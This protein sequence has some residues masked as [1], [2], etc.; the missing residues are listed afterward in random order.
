[1]T[2]E[3]YLRIVL[4][5]LAESNLPKIRSHA[6]LSEIKNLLVPLRSEF[7]PT[8]INTDI[9]SILNSIAFFL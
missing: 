8:Y 3:I 4:L 6:I 7:L 1:M 2:P 9:K 5:A